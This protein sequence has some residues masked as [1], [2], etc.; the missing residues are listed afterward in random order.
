MQKRVGSLLQSQ[1]DWRTLSPSQCQT[2]RDHLFPEHLAWQQLVG[3]ISTRKSW[4][5]FIRSQAN[6]LGLCKV[7]RGHQEEQLQGKDKSAHTSSGS[8]GCLS[9]MT[10]GSGQEVGCSWSSWCNAHLQCHSRCSQN[11]GPWSRYGDLES[12]LLP[13]WWPAPHEDAQETV[14][15]EP[16][17][18]PGY[19][20]ALHKQG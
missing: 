12:R 18:L 13:E 20:N 8:P 2:G 7:L 14:S 16:S 6:S 5:Q 1:L 15:S 17:L 9:G 19:P 10:S 11:P 3:V 4:K